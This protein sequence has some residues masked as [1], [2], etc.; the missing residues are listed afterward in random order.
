MCMPTA[1]CIQYLSDEPLPQ[2]LLDGG[3]LQDYLTS[4]M[5]SP[6]YGLPRR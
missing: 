6:M 4:G 1:F 2:L 5:H 3:S